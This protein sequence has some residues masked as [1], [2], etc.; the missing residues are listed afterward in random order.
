MQALRKLIGYPTGADDPCRP[1]DFAHTAFA[2]APAGVIAAYTCAPSDQRV[3]F[4]QTYAK[5]GQADAERDA[6]SRGG[7][8]VTKMPCQDGE[9]LG[10]VKWMRTN[11]SGY[12]VCLR[13]TDGGV[14]RFWDVISA[15]NARM[16]V[17]VLDR[18]RVED[19]VG[20]FSRV[21]PKT[22]F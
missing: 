1:T 9:P 13:R 10:P 12:Y 17:A 4:F 18:G 8:A 6:I 7:Q 19:A 21:K 20:E 22:I 15:N 2:E 11:D 3:A 5:P 14:T 16:L